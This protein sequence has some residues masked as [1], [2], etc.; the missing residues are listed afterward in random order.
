MYRGNKSRAEL[1]NSKEPIVE[2]AVKDTF[3]I[4]LAD[5]CINTMTITSPT[6]CM[7]GVVEEEI[8][9]P[10][11]MTSYSNKRHNEPR[12]Q[13]YGQSQ[14][15]RLA[16][17]TAGGES[18]RGAQGLLCDGQHKLEDCLCLER[19]SSSHTVPLIIIIF[20]GT[21]YMM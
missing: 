13:T 7:E 21:L 5:Q 16:S 14:R 3:M 11:S 8:L 18:D 1:R 20:E 10:W 19:D 12:L 4:V 2:S 6:I 15:C 17:P 9:Q